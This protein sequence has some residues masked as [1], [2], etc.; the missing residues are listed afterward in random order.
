MLSFL[1]R[2]LG[3][4]L[5]VIGVMIVLVFFGVN[6][7]GDP[8]W[9]LIS[10][11]MDQEAIA[12][13][14]AAL[15]LDKP[16]TEQ[17]FHFVAGIFQG[18][19]GRSFVHGEPAIQLILSRMGATMELAFAALFL[20]IV[21]GL[22][23]GMY[24]GLFPER[25][26]SRAIMAGSI[27]GF[28]LPTF[29]VGLMLILLFSVTLGWLPASGRGET[30]EF[31]GFQTSLLTLNGWQ[32]LILPAFN[33]ALLK[34]SL[35]TRLARAGTREAML[36]DYVKFARA[37]GLSQSLIVR[38]H[39]LKN[40]MIP[41]IT[42]IGLEFG[43]LVAFSVVTETIFSWP[44]MGKLLLEA[45][46]RL[47][48]PVIVAYIMVV[49]ILFVVINLIVDILYSILDPRVRLGDAKG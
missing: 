17:F 10:P 22:P 8:I 15:G 48:R 42:V 27:L 28:S 41:I 13:T 26:S 24:A 35:I 21:L 6:V 12:K 40:I 49:V 11:E 14:A 36:M 5:L 18:D 3:Q 47:D 25:K 38:V 44:G 16:I 20:S 7:V 45:I 33:L 30:V 23:L 29:W 46:Q 37:K 39:V 34:I 31:L 2:R 43:S 1:I 4:A 19:F 9:M 32:H